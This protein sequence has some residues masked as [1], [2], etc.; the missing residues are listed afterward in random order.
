MTTVPDNM[1]FNLEGKL[2]QI[3]LSPSN[4]LLPIFEAVINSIHATKDSGIKKGLIEINLY[5][6][7][8]QAQIQTNELDTRP[9]RE[10]T[11]QDNGIG[12]NQINYNSFKT[13]NSL[14]KLAIG[15][16]GVGRFTWLKAFESVSIISVYKSGQQQFKR[17]LN[18]N[19]NSGIHNHSS[20]ESQNLRRTTVVKLI[21][22]KND[23][24]KKFPVDINT[25]AEKAIRHCMD[26]FVLE[27]CPTII[28]RDKN[29]DKEIILNDIYRLS[30]HKL[31]PTRFRIKNKVFDL[32][33]YKITNIKTKHLLHYCANNRE[34]YANSLSKEIPELNRKIPGE[35]DGDDFY[36]H[37]YL[38]GQYLD[39]IVNTDRTGFNFP[40]TEEEDIDFPDEISEKELKAN[41]IRGIESSISSFLSKVRDDKLNRIRKYVEK[42]AP[43]YRTLFKHKKDKLKKLPILSEAKLE[44]ELFKILHELEVETK[45]EGRTILNKIKTA[46]DFEKYQKDYNKYI[47]KV[48]EI[49]NTNLSKYIIHRKVVLSL[50]EKTFRKNKLGKFA[51]ESAVHRLIFPLNSSTDDVSY[52]DHNLWIIDEKLAY[53]SYIAS[54]KPFEKLEPVEV[55]SKKRADIITFNEYF[56]NHYAF[57]TKK[58]G[59]FQSIVLIEFKRPMRDD[60]NE[61]DDN[62]IAQII[63]YVDILRE[64]KGRLKNGRKFNITNIPIYCY[65]ISDLTSKLDKIAKGYGYTPTQDGEGYFGFNPNLGC[66]IEIVSYDKLIDDAKQRN[67]ILFDKLKLP[68]EEE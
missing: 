66:Y 37:G 38:K 31:E 56:N 62:P 50:L 6:D 58:S 52:E 30:I 67:Q 25:I 7:E 9:V 22:L 51:K 12:F 16:K 44:I 29:N 32:N 11:I 8:S 24:R 17:T 28:F 2:N 60:Y 68:L 40:K 21:N 26:Y 63:K 20:E 10:V 55:N 61:N 42:K 15:G 13:A 48:I 3:R 27:D 41:V 36:I 18:F 65:I 34:V 43:Q 47:E 14:H 23:F 35:K 4:V 53:H 54:D 49:G 59:P 5:R 57:S 45:K 33:V 1:Y 19:I 64:G 39:E 46:E